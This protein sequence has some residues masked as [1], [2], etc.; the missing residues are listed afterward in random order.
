LNQKIYLPNVNAATK[1]AE[2]EE[3]TA[4]T[5]ATETIVAMKTVKDLP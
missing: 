2:T 4:A 3:T 1:E 5:I